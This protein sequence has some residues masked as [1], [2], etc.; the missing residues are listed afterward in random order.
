MTERV[1]VPNGKFTI[2]IAPGSGTRIFISIP[3]V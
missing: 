1:T 3:L 2:R